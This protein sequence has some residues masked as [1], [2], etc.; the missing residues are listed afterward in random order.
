MEKRTYLAHEFELR[1]AD[2]RDKLRGHVVTVFLVWHARIFKNH[3]YCGENISPRDMLHEIQLVWIRAP[4][5]RNNV[6]MCHTMCTAL[7][8][9]VRYKW[10]ISASRTPACVL[11]MQHASY[12]Y[13]RRACPLSSIHVPTTC[14]LTFKCFYSSV[15]QRSR[16]S[17]DFR[18]AKHLE[19]VSV[20]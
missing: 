18:S 15:V 2:T 9:Y 4:W 13:T 5:S 3:P 12:I 1:S 10:T 16:S 19:M 11:F 17:N 20:S 8:H 7:A 6:S 14:P